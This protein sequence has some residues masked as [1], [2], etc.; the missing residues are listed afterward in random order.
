MG[1]L[2]QIGLFESSET[3]FKIFVDLDGVLCDWDRAFIELGKELT[4]GL[5]GQEFED[6]YGR[7]ALWKL[8]A[9]EGNL[10]FWSEMDWMPDGKKL[11]NYVKKYNPTIFTTP[12]KSK[13]SKDGKE[14]WIRRELGPKVPFI[15]EKDKYKYADTNSILIDNY[16]KKI[17]DWINLGD[18]IGILHQSAD[19]TIEE[20]KKY[21][22]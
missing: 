19:K 17:N 2:E 21:G 13:L 20:L 22:Q 16:D 6:K 10:E 1:I 11:W 3:K 5:T 4:K 15:F 8:I 12:A 9:K 7:D 18:G 14:I